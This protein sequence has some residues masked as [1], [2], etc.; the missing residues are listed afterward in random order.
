M[1]GSANA[2]TLL[3]FLPGPNQFIFQHLINDLYS[4]YY[5][6]FTL[7]L[8]IISAESGHNITGLNSEFRLLRLSLVFPRV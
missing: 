2:L 3:E 6:A 8:D 5:P 4:I 7:N 1:R